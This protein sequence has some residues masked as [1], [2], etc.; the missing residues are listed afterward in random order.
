MG[1]PVRFGSPLKTGY[2]TA[3]PTLR[4]QFATPP[5]AG[6][7]GVL[8]NGEAGLTPWCTGGYDGR[9][10]YAPPRNVDAIR[11]AAAALRQL[12]LVSSRAPTRHPS[13]S[14]VVGSTRVARRAGT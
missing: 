14:A 9:V 5:V 3:L 4:E 6:L 12:R 2:R 1:P 13:R 7:E 8:M 10:P 11:V